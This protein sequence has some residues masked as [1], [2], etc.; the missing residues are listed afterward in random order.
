MYTLLILFGFYIMGCILAIIVAKYTNNN[1]NPTS[2]FYTDKHDIITVA[3]LS[4]FSIDILIT[5]LIFNKFIFNS[6]YYN[7]FIEWF[8]ED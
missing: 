4:W 6:N 7:K 8:E 2:R 3:L 5:V 1:I